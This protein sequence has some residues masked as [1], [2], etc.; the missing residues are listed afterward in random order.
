MSVIL[1]LATILP[2]GIRSQ[3]NSYAFFELHLFIEICANYD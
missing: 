3:T 1:I 2:D